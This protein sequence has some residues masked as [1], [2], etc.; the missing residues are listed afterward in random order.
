LGAFGYDPL[1]ITSF[2]PEREVRDWLQRDPIDINRRVLIDWGVLTQPKAEAIEAEVRKEVSEAMD[3]SDK[4]PFCKPED[5]L[6]N[7]FVEG[8]VM[9]R[10]LA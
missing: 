2:R 7:V 5:G 9:A 1:A 6:K 3:W 4:Q 10:Q 8:T